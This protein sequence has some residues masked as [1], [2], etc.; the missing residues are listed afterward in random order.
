MYAKLIVSMFVGLLAVTTIT[1]CGQSAAS[2]SG[3]GNN[4]SYRTPQSRLPSGVASHLT[5]YEQRIVV[6][7]KLPIRY[8]LD[9]S[10]TYLSIRSTN[11][12]YIDP[13]EAYAIT[14]YK[15]IWYHI[16]GV[17]TVVWTNTTKSIAAKEWLSEGYKTD[18]L[19]SKQTLYTNIQIPTPDSYHLHGKSWSELPGVLKSN[20]VTEWTTFFHSTK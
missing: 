12:L 18:P 16:K 1:A 8:A 2:P 14:Q 9:P 4:I 3:N 5:G 10:G 6:R 15:T 13:T 20:Q 7:T 17:P 11:I 19:P